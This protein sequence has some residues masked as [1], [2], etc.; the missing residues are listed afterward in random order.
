M[1][2]TQVHRHFRNSTWRF[3]LQPDESRYRQKNLSSVRPDLLFL[4]LGKT[5]LEFQRGQA[6]VTL[7]TAHASLLY[8]TPLKSQVQG[9][10][11]TLLSPGQLKFC[12]EKAK[13]NV[14]WEKK[15]TKAANN[16]DLIMKDTFVSKFSDSWMTSYLFVKFLVSNPILY[17]SWICVSMHA[18]APHQKCFTAFKVILCWLID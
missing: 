18:K 14:H 1:D 11:K 3:L 6:T 15:I 2:L 16:N 13:E 4:V 9:K 5:F 17:Y 10:K 7:S 12:L 8:L